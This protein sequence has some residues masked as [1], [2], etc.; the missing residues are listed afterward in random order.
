MNKPII[1][2]EEVKRCFSARTTL[3]GIGVKV[4][5]LRLFESIEQQ[6]KIDQKVVRYTPSEKLLDGYISTSPLL[7]KK[8]LQPMNW[9]FVKQ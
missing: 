6:V 7:I 4:R 1:I 9:R 5:Q 2:S 8:Y 3:A